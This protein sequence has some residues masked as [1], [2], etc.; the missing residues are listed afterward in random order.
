MVV[1][2]GETG[3]GGLIAYTNDGG[4]YDPAA[5]VWTPTTTFEAPSARSSHTAVWTG[6]Q[7]LVW[8]GF[9]FFDDTSSGLTTTTCFDTLF[10]YTP[11]RNSYLYLRP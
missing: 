8:G 11:T 10:A 3:L 7:M 9:F 5:N 4:Q 1:W 6:N 2:G